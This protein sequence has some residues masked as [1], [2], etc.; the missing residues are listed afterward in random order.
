MKKKFLLFIIFG[1]FLFFAN[2][3]Q[4]NAKGLCAIKYENHF[5][6]T[7]RVIF[8]N[9]SKWKIMIYMEKASN[10]Q[11][12]F[13]FSSDGSYKCDN[14]NC[15]FKTVNFKNGT[16]KFDKDGWVQLDTPNNCPTGVE[17]AGDYNLDQI[18]FDLSPD[19]N[20]LDYFDSEIIDNE[21]E[22]NGVPD[23]KPNKTPYKHI[24]VCNFI[25]P[26]L[27]WVKILVPILIILLSSM[28]FFKAVFANEDDAM[29]KAYGRL[30]KRLMIAVVIFLIPSLLE[31]LIKNVL[32]EIFD[33]WF[34]D[35]CP[36][37]K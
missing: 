10:T 31:W 14:N 25:L 12:Y 32:P 5:G 29:K 7:D 17:L 30:I 9:N 8:N 2:E 18:T 4:V 3:N 16:L 19:G 23:E 28:D 36:S 37:L 20:G 33:N 6:E 35:W 34:L 13:T 27:N 1:V 22:N 21:Y 11:S 26:I 24:D 15:F